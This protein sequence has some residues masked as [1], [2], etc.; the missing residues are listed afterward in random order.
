MDQSRNATQDWI[1][2]LSELRQEIPETQFRRF[3]APTMGRRWDHGIVLS[4]S[5]AFAEGMDWLRQPHHHGLA[6]DALSRVVK[7]QASVRFFCDRQPPPSTA[8]A[9][10]E[11]I[12]PAASEG[13]A[14]APDAAAAWPQSV[15]GSYY[16]PRHGAKLMP[17]RWPVAGYL[18]VAVFYCPSRA[19]GY[20][21]TVSMSPD[22]QIGIIR[23]V[24]DDRGEIS[25][26]QLQQLVLARRKRMAA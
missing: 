3:L 6:N 11:Q 20:R 13:V 21:C 22:A 12:A 26:E 5:T 9:G 14:E 8:E 23:D 18:R 15:D 7:G 24:Q 1:S 19:D 2:C 16:C 25:P 4:V 10:T 17:C